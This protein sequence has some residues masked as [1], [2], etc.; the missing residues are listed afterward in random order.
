LGLGYI[1]L[2]RHKPQRVHQARRRARL[3]ALG[4]VSAAYDVTGDVTAV[5]GVVSTTSS[6]QATSGSY[7]RSISRGTDIRIR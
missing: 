2:A 7:V 4:G 5:L 6:S 3:Y 1:R